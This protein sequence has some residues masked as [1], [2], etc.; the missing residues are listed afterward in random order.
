MQFAFSIIRNI[1]EG[2]HQLDF[3]IDNY[4][5]LVQDIYS[6][7]KSCFLGQFITNI[8]SPNVD[9]ESGPE[10]RISRQDSCRY[11][12]LI[13]SVPYLELYLELK[14]LQKLSE[15]DYLDTNWVMSLFREVMDE[16]FEWMSS[17][18][19]IWT[20]TAENLAVNRTK[21]MQDI[22]SRAEAS[23]LSAGLSPLRDLS[24]EEWPANAAILA[25]HKLQELHANKSLENEDADATDDEG[26]HH[27]VSPCR[28][29]NPVRH[30]VPAVVGCTRPPFPV[31]VGFQ[32]QRRL[33]RID[34]DPSNGCL[35][36]IGSGVM[37]RRLG[38]GL[39]MYGIGPLGNDLAITQERGLPSAHLGSGCGLS[40]TSKK[41]AARQP[42]SGHERHCQIQVYDSQSLAWRL[43]LEPFTAP[44]AANFS[45]GVHCNN[46]IHWENYPRAHLY[47]NINKDTIGSLPHAGVPWR[48]E[49][50]GAAVH[51]QL[52]ESNGCLYHFIIVSHLGHKSIAVYELQEDYSQW[53]LK[54]HDDFGQLPGKSRI[55]S[56]I[57]G[58]EGETCTI[59][60]H[61]PGRIT[62]YRF[63]NKSSEELIDLTNQ[64]FYL[65]HSVQFDSRDIFQ[66]GENLAP[67]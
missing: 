58:A 24:D 52:Q 41:M 33:I 16:T 56:Y 6:R 15:D 45:S 32:R 46:V 22:V 25:L 38:V 50:G 53:F 59:I 1:F 55:L 44:I 28:G 11:S 49:G 19:E 65:E 13:P 62:A 60:T 26:S 36:L 3:E 63:L 4:E 9:H 42:P 66:F 48:R 39:I 43:C 51:C 18:P 8:F 67:V 21:F 20:I 37:Y 34:L 17:K 29:S 64:P 54:Y 61:V 23:F 30:L 2:M 31:T 40:P 7:L 57:R 35:S 5:M 12:D 14:K 47:Y 27:R 10:I